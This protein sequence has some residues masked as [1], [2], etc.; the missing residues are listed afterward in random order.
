MAQKD[1]KKTGLKHH[2]R[3]FVRYELPRYNARINYAYVFLIYAILVAVAHGQF[4]LPWL[5]IA[6]TFALPMVISPLY[7]SI[8]VARSKPRKAS[9]TDIDA[10]NVRVL[11][12]LVQEKTTRHEFMARL[13]IRVYKYNEQLNQPST[14]ASKNIVSNN[15]EMMRLQYDILDYFAR[16]GNKFSDVDI[17]DI[18]ITSP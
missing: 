8:R 2:A 13:Y 11:S 7:N 16:E 4:K 6:A 17:K 12:D 1:K 10:S 15:I 5:V 9:L 3:R 18:N 14:P